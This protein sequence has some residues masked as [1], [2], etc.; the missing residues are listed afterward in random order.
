VQPFGSD[1]TNPAGGIMAGAADMAKWLIVQLDSGRIRGRD[2]RLFSAQSAAE[3]WTLVTPIPMRDPP[4]ELAPQR[5]GF[6][7]YALGFQV[8]DYRGH[9]ALMHTGGL[10]GYVS[11]VF[12]IPDLKLG[13]SVLTNQESG[14]AF[15][16]IAYRVLDH[17]MAAPTHDWL[18]GYRTLAERGRARDAV[19][20]EGAAQARDSLS[21]P[22]LPLA[23]YAGTYRDPWYGEISIAEN[24]RKLVIRML[25]T[26]SLVGDLEHWHHDTFVARWHDRELRADAFVTFLLQPDGTVRE[27]SI[28]PASPSVD[29][30]FDFQDLRPVRQPE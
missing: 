8:R 24:G 5:A 2:Q 7:G 4:A 17:Y 18:A 21:T 11:R 9:K 1:N 29:F 19:A 14:A 25:P 6:N 10:P 23:R 27:L 16:A 15:D 3:L 28:V 20:D 26:P 12:M 22:S 30:S 13:I